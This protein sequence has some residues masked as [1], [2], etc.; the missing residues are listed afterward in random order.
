MRI[1]EEPTSIQVKAEKVSQL[2]ED[3][4]NIP[5]EGAIDAKHVLRWV[6]QFL[7]ED[8]EFLLDELLHIL[9]QAYLSKEFVRRSLEDMFEYFRKKFNFKTVNDLLDH[10]CFLSCQGESKSQTI[11]L[12]FIDE[13]VLKNYGRSVNECGSKEIKYWFYLDDVLAS[14][15]TFRR[16]I[17]KEINDYG[18][19]A[20]IDDGMNV[21]AVF[22][23]LHTWGWAN[24]EYILKQEFGAKIDARIDF[25]HFDEIMNNPRRNFFVGPQSHNHAYPRKENQEQSVL[26]YLDSLGHADKNEEFAYRAEGEPKKEVFFSSP[27]ARI[28]YENIIL[29]KGVE[30]INE[31][32]RTPSRGLRPLGFTTPSHKTF[33]LGSHAFTW[34]NIS[35]TCPLVY[36][37]EANGWYPLF[38]VKN[39]G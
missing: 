23:V 13:I 34:R 22:F 30:M 20:F 1:V 5:P 16:E 17:S 9:P 4:E 11:L 7:D 26:D 37:W 32:E 8:Q 36:W 25:Y 21:L 38:P 33:G 14:G 6:N 10:C 35:N 19:K 12:E 27:E 28:R 15:G 3:Y 39:R 29:K 18:G 24:T 2:I 31:I